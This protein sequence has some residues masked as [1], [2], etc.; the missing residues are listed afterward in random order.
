MY[1]W[2]T[3]VCPKTPFHTKIYISIVNGITALKEYFFD[4]GR[5]GFDVCYQTPS[6][7]KDLPH[8]DYKSIKYI[9]CIFDV[10]QEAFCKYFEH[11]LQSKY[12]YK[13]IVAVFHYVSQQIRLQKEAAEQWDKDN[14]ELSIHIYIYAVVGFPGFG[15]ANNCLMLVT[16]MAAILLLL[17][18]SPCGQSTVFGPT[19]K[20]IMYVCVLGHRANSPTLLTVRFRNR[21]QNRCVIGY[22]PLNFQR[23]CLTGVLI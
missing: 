17:A 16:L 3:L 12:S 10:V 6:Q 5:L 19:S 14:E 23:Q 22:W 15:L 7:L 2:A 13:Y 11:H 21:C 8:N 18:S 1:S 20:Y 4:Y 9:E